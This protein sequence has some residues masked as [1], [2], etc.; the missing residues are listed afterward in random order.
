M[1]IIHPMKLALLALAVLRILAYFHSLRWMHR[2][3]HHC[4]S[5]LTKVQDAVRS[6]LYS[7]KPLPSA[8]SSLSSVIIITVTSIHKV[9]HPSISLKIMQDA[10]GTTIEQI[11]LNE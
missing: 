6:I 10:L 5:S 8:K 4:I 1:L 7:M 11:L 2:S 9:P 3:V